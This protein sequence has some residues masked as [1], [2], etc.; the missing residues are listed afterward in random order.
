MV[1][2]VV[3]AGRG[4]PSS[5]L[6]PPPSPQEALQSIATDPGLYQMLPRFSTFISEGV[7]RGEWG[8][9]PG[10]WLGLPIPALPGGISSPLAQAALGGCAEVQGRAAPAGLAPRV[11]SLMGASSC[12]VAWP[13]DS[14]AP[15][16]PSPPPRSV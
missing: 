16:L 13:P 12:G 14:A 4:A 6:P 2:L 7:R 9:S 8:I 3:A 1:C 10:L 5:D 15:P 11:G